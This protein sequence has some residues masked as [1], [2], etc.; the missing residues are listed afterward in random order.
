MG[1]G[2]ASDQSEKRWFMSDSRC[3]PIKRRRL[4]RVGA[5]NDSRIIES[6]RCRWAVIRGW[7]NQTSRATPSRQLLSHQ[8]VNSKLMLCWH[9]GA[10]KCVNI[11][12]RSRKEIHRWQILRCDSV[13][14]S[15]RR[16]QRRQPFI[17]RN[18]GVGSSLTD[19]IDK[20]VAESFRFLNRVAD[21][22]PTSSASSSTPS[23]SS[24]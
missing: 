24:L 13:T 12:L 8:T 7:K 22:R 3:P 17:Q 16:K 14:S 11:E 15:V 10:A 5:I 18:G 1:S 6:S 20:F 2:G 4:D 19:V 9:R 21:V 23:S